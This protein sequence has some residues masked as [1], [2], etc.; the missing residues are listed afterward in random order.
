MRTFDGTLALKTNMIHAPAEHWQWQEPGG[1]WR[2]AG[3]YHVTLTVTDRQPL[4]GKLVMPDGDPA[5]ARVV[6]TA[7]GDALVECLMSIS[8]YHAEVQV[9]HFCLMPDHM[10]AVLYVRRRMEQGIR[11]VVRGF[12]QASKKL[13]RVCSQSGAPFVV[14]NVIREELKEESR[15]L[16]AAAAALCRE[17][18][19][20]AYYRLPPVFTEMPFIRPMAR[21]AQLPTT[22]RYIDMNPQR[23]ATKRLKPGFFRVQKNV[24][25]GPR[26]YD[27]VGNVALLQESAYAPVHVRHLW[28]E[29]A[30]HG[31]AKAC[32]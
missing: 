19:E 16:E 12:W 1:A 31:D 23:L 18:G 17:M 28:V 15:R 22:I 26:R 32:R 30:Q 20:E 27:G 4:L 8:R 9:L 6:R 5:R 7:L 25:I 3:L 21:Y 29:K 24:E 10:H 2:G 13:G 11:S 14:P